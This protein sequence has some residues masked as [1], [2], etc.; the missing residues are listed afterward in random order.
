MKTPRDLSAT[1]LIKLLKKFGYEI[2]RQK[3]SHI[4]LSVTIGEVT[5]H[6]TIPNHNPLKLGTLLSIVNDVSDFLKI[7]KTE[8]L[9]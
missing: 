5:H 3:G 4:R 1:D 9:K 8:I 7:P 2:T 6:V